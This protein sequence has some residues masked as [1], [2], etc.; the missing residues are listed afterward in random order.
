MVALHGH[1]LR[2][3]HGADGNN[4]ARDYGISRQE[5][6]EFALM[7]QQRAGEAWKAC[8]LAEE[9]VPV[10]WARASGP[11]RIERDDH[12]RP[13]TTMEDL[14][15]LPTAFDKD[16][17]VTA[18]NAS[19]IVDGAA[20]LLLSTAAEGAGAGL[21]A[22][23]PHRLLGDRGRRSVAHGHRSGAGDPRRARRRRA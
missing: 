15:G 5:Q 3:L 10:R 13:E 16:G 12:L 1:L 20:M 21:E 22:A 17:F 2:L 14:A 8:R 19:G 6:D 9:V 11:R 23:R 18:G 7:S 4:L